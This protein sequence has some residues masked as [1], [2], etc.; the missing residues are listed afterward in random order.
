VTWG[1]VL[2]GGGGGRGGQAQRPRSSVLQTDLSTPGPTVSPS[3][4]EP[5]G[6]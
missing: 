4:A 2:P 6:A 5:S 1:F 3:P